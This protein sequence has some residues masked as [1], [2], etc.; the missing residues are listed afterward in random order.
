M[1]EENKKPEDKKPEAAKP[2]P[3]AKPAAKEPPPPP[4]PPKPGEFGIYLETVGIKSE[5]LGE[6]SAGTEM[7]EIEAKDLVAACTNLKKNKGMIYLSNMT[8][9]DRK[10]GLQSSIQL[11]NPSEKKYVVV[12]VTVPKDNPIVPSLT[13]L[14]ASANW[15]EREAWD[16]LG[17]KYEGHPNLTRILNPDNWEGHP[18]R[19]DYVGPVDELNQPLSYQK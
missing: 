1:S 8:G 10:A 2:A 4:E 19:K 3:A 9:V 5:P 17:I 11:E 12:K 7:L 18:L 14:F 15:L 16:L 13:E 6:D